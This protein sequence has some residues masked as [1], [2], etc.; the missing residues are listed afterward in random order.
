MASHG[1]ITNCIGQLKRGD[2]AAAWLLWQRYFHRLVGLARQKLGGEPRG[3]ADEED[4]A[5]S[6]LDSFCRGAMSG[7]YAQLVDRDDLWHLLS[8]L[9]A[10]KAANLAR[11]EHAQKRRGAAGPGPD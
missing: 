4:V 10:R 9:T 1:S 11:H 7:Q 8:V 6:A 5:L 2:S 3:I